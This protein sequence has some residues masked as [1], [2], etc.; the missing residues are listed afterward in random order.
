MENPFLT[1]NS[2]LANIE[3]MLLDIK[4]GQPTTQPEKPAF[5]ITRAEAAAR[6]RITLS[7]LD[8]YSRLGV[9]QSY[10]VGGRIRFK[11]SEL[12][13]AFEAVKNQKYRRG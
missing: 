4:H 3:T 5:Y 6:L 1:I 13:Q 8:K 10:K 7:T 2:R 9:I 11:S 12:D